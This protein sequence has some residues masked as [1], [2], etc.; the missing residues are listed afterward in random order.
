M[1]QQE[2]EFE[3]RFDLLFSFFDELFFMVFLL[4]G[5]AWFVRIWPNRIQFIFSS[6]WHP[7]PLRLTNTRTFAAHVFEQIQW[8]R[9]GGLHYEETEIQGIPHPCWKQHCAPEPQSSA[10]HSVAGK[11][12]HR[13]RGWSF[14]QSHVRPCQ[15]NLKTTYCT[16]W[17]KPFILL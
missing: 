11:S 16:D 2:A 17:I 3:M 7:I 9:K 12:R 5:L 15:E 14:A 13:L 1:G 8:R 4:K 6:S 10:E